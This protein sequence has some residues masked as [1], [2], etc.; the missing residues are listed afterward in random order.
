MTRPIFS[1]CC[2]TED[3]VSV[4]ELIKKYNLGGQVPLPI[5][6]SCSDRDVPPPCSGGRR[7]NVAQATRQ[8]K[9]T[10]KRQLGDA[11]AKGQMNVRKKTRYT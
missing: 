6:K 1:I 2:E 3:I 10:K 7:R 9:K 11:V 8:N 4:D 5:C